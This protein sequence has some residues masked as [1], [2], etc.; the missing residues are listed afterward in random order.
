MRPELRSENR[1][2]E[3]CIGTLPAATDA[4]GLSGASV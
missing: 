4:Q 2:L 1:K 3:E